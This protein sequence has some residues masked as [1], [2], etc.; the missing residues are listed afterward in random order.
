MDGL[1]GASS[2]ITICDVVH[3][4]WKLHNRIK[5]APAAWNQYREKLE[6]LS[7]V[8]NNLTATNTT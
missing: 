8:R 1:G 6:S 4:I 3:R 7:R 2:I 5:A